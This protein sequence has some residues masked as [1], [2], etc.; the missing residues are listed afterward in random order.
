MNPHFQHASLL[1]MQIF[2]FRRVAVAMHF[3]P[4]FAVHDRSHVLDVVYSTDAPGF[5]GLLNS[6]RSLASNTKS[7]QQCIIHVVVPKDDMEK[8]K[9]LVECFHKT[10]PNL[11]VLPTVML[12]EIKPLHINMSMASSYITEAHWFHAPA[13]A[14]L[15]IPEYMPLASRALWLDTD[16]IVQTDVVSLLDFPMKHT[17]A[18]ALEH[19]TIAGDLAGSLLEWE[20]DYAQSVHKNASNWF[21]S[22]VLLIDV[23][24]WLWE[25]R[26]PRI[27]RWFPYLKGLQGDELMLNFHFVNNFDILDNMWNLGCLT[28]PELT[29]K[30][31]IEEAHILHWSC[32]SKKPWD[33][34]KLPELGLNDIYWD[35]YRPKERCGD[36]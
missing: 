13:F 5:V 9:E 3:Q 31:Q 25:G 30:S 8:A 7:P 36:W 12:H 16:T 33:E 17:L 2:Y 6:M 24:K 28:V 4:N 35:K 26:G 34:D 15:Y 18:A 32:S 27:S 19:P 22:G 10:L 21:N 14:R 29:T 20:K 1:L 23:Q 11:S